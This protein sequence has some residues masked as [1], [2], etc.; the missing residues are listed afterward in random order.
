MD[1]SGVK[2]FPEWCHLLCS[3]KRFHF[4]HVCHLKIHLRN[5]KGVSLP[6]LIRYCNLGHNIFRHFDIFPKFSFTTSETSGDY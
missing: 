5:K 6:T 1:D 3:E 4:N 2:D